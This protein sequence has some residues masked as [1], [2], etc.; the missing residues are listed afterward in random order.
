MILF[1]TMSSR[2]IAERCAMR[3]GA[4]TVKHFS[5][6]E[7]FVRIDEDVHSQDVWV[8]A[9]TQTPA[10]NLL[11]LFFLLDA[12]QTAGAR[13]HLFISYFSYAR[14]VVTA[15]GQARSAQVISSFFSQFALKQ[16]IILHAHDSRVHDLLS[17]HDVYATNFFCNAA[18][19]YDA[20]VAP[21]KGAYI[22]AQEIAKHCGKEIIALTKT[23]FDEQVKIIT[24]EGA[25]DGKRL[26][27]VD[28][29]V[30]TGYTLIEAAQVLKNAGATS[31][32]AAVTHGVFSAGAVERLEKS[33]LE[34]I[35][36]TNSIKQPVRGGKTKV[37]DISAVICEIMQEL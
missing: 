29:I 26:L 36:V 25:V 20:I 24:V 17:Y 18:Q 15:Q 34:S 9:S 3:L 16:I 32:A 4:C 22:W 10:D 23:R 28:D 8:L 13:I 5:D 11:E 2:H 19:G 31:V 21:D 1:S 27:I 7:L 12:L 30:S 37:E 33:I 6:G 14:Q 35:T